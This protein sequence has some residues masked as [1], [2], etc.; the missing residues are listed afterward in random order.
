M[1][2]KRSTIQ[3]LHFLEQSVC[4]EPLKGVDIYL[5]YTQVDAQAFYQSCGFVWI[6]DSTS[7]VTQVQVE[8]G[9]FAWLLPDSDKHA[10]IPHMRL[11]S[12]PY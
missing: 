8:N 5:Q 10:I 11:C 6:N 2:I 3:L 12:V 1:L 7:S 9:G 4:W